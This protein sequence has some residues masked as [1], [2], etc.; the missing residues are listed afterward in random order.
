MS[1]V[2]VLVVDDEEFNRQTL[3]Y[4]LEPAGFL[5]DEAGDG[6]E[7]WFSLSQGRN[8]YDAILLDRQMPEMDG[9]ELLAKIKAQPGLQDIPVIMQTA[10]DREQ[11]I[12]DGIDA[13]AHYYLTKPYDVDVLTSVVRAATDEF[14]RR[15]RL[16]SELAKRSGA[17]RL[18]EAGR[19]RLRTQKEA[20]ALAVLLASGLPRS[21][22]VA[23]GLSELLI[24]AVEHGN[25]ELD[26]ASKSELMAQGA[27]DTVIEERLQLAPYSERAVTLEVV[28]DGGVATF[29]ITDEGK[30]FDWQAFVDLTAARAFD[31]HGRGIAMARKMSFAT[32]TYK[33]RG[34]IVEASVE[35]DDAA[36]PAASP[37]S[38]VP[39]P[40]PVVV[41]GRGL[42]A[43]IEDRLRAVEGWTV[44]AGGGADTVGGDLY[45]TQSPAGDVILRH[46]DARGGVLTLPAAPDLVEGATRC[47]VLPATMEIGSPAEQRLA[48]AL[49]Q[50]QARLVP[51]PAALGGAGVSVAAWGAAC[52]SVN[53]D[54]WGGRVRDSGRIALFVADMTGHGPVAGMNTFRLAALLDDPEI[55]EA[56]PDAV[57]RFLDR[58]L[59]AALPAG[60]YAAMVYG[61][62][63]A[64]A[65]RFDYAAAGVPHPVVFDAAGTVAATGL[66]KGLP[67][68]ASGRFPYELRQLDIPAGGALV[69][70]TDG[71]FTLLDGGH[72]G[73]G[74]FDR[75]LAAMAAVA[76]GGP[77]AARLEAVIAGFEGE[78]GDDVTAVCVTLPG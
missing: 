11:E 30:G 13:G 67:V 70:I 21:G 72:G 51:Q 37:S 54:M 76:G 19:F 52:S 25:L 35:T 45:L 12:I 64:A 46:G 71:M 28:R 5:I 43:A 38:P 58:E 77:A 2:R 33:G 75:F 65:R 55:A 17:I 74:A 48:A 56:S 14:A 41:A 32:L 6:A 78:R 1:N 27:W 23:M 36:R 47:L 61:V 62:L 8:I 39:E 50:H 24:N 15:R 31:S 7:A 49:A 10:M 34:N 69:M 9:M 68:G 20:D 60:E 40:L 63:D 26:Y 44:V 53:G 57:L 73:A 16:K 42:A 18:M 29:T 4:C 66:G 59:K 22:A 3:R